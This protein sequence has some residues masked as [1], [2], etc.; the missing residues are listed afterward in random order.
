MLF[1]VIRISFR[2]NELWLYVVFHSISPLKCR[3]LARSLNVFFC[4][5]AIPFRFVNENYH[6]IVNLFVVLSNM[7]FNFNDRIHFVSTINFT[8]IIS[9]RMEMDL[10]VFIQFIFIFFEMDAFEIEAYKLINWNQRRLSIPSL[11]F[12]CDSLR[13][14]FYKMKIFSIHFEMHSLDEMP[15]KCSIFSICYFRCW[16]TIAIENLGHVFMHDC[17][18]QFNFSNLNGHL[19]RWRVL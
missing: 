2:F 9:C 18:I 3:T 10:K 17:W 8:S 5:L 1:S 11:Q 14:F 16:K 7:H 15:S 4:L 6:L 13:Y 19:I 12:R